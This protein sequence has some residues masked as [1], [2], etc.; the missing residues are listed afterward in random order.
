MADILTISKSILDGT[1]DEKA[2]DERLKRLI[3]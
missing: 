2:E 1:F 3:E